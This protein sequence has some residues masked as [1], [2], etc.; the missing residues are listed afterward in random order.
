MNPSN[1]VDFTLWTDG[2]GHSDG[3]GGICCVVKDQDQRGVRM[4]IAAMSESSVDRC[5]FMA[6]IEGLRL[7]ME[8]WR[9]N[10][11]AWTYSETE[12]YGRT[13]KIPRIK[14]YS[15][16]ES[17]VLSVKGVYD[18][19]NC[20]DLWA[21]FAWYESRIDLNA[22]H[23]TEPVTEE[24]PEFVEC[25]LQSSTMRVMLKNYFEQ[26][27][28]VCDPDAAKPRKQKAKPETTNQ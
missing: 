19:S 21:A 24:M 6:L 8:M 11:L 12:Q 22:N 3:V 26:T 4:A 13:L 2:S 17:L 18:R 23:I 9:A 10:P 20:E 5:E 27:P 1:D 15:D 25:D 14:W 16:R 7:V 28:L